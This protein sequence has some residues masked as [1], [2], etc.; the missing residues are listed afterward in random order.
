MSFQKDEMLNGPLP[1]ARVVIAARKGS[2]PREV[3]TSMLVWSDKV[4][5]TIGGGALEMQAIA[6]A[7]EVL[8]TGQ[9][10]LHRQ[11]LGP[12]LGQCCGGAVTTL[13]ERWDRDALASV[14]DVVARPLPGTVGDMPGSATRR[15]PMAEAGV[16]EGWLIEPVAPPLRNLWIWGAGHVGTALLN[17]L[18]P[19]PGFQISWADPHPDRFAPNL[20]DHVRTLTAENPADLVTLAPPDAEHFVMTY[21]H[22]MD[23]DICHRIM[24]RTFRSLGV[25]GSD[26][27]KA[28]FR[29]RLKALGHAPHVIDR[30]ECPI[31]DPTLGRHPQAIALGVVAGVLKGGKLGAEKMEKSA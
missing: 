12:D 21:S 25:I 20:P 9:A 23:L 22:A 18:S 1:V 19:L 14:E 29:S 3:G 15:L 31:G 24:G 10:R 8:A 17:V 26:T 4:L 28:R 30:M 16:V 2:S 11:P 27:K 5:G 13:I 6:H 7:R